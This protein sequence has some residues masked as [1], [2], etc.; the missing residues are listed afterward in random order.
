MIL[1]SKLGFKEKE[2]TAFVNY[3]K[4]RRIQIIPLLQSV[5]WL[6]YI[7]KHEKYSDLR[8]KEDSIHQACPLNPGTFKL[9]TE[10]YDEMFDCHRESE[11]FHVGGDEPHHM[12]VCPQCGEKVEKQGRSKLYF[13]YILKVCDHVRKLG[14][15]P[16][17][18]GDMIVNDPPRDS[19]LPNDIVAL[20]WDYWSDG[21]KVDWAILGSCA[22]EF[23]GHVDKNSIGKIPKHIYH[24]FKKYWDPGDGSF[25]GKFNG[26]SHIFL[27]MLYKLRTTAMGQAR[28]GVPSHRD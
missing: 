4:E 22:A 13:D 24:K 27:S 3:C 8:E 12:G 17:I 26:F 7:L 6:N 18:W 20:Y 10:L 11:Y 15:I 14:K 23:K 28:V 19:K 1:Q 25:P 9:F 5:N 16:M 21:P 2:I